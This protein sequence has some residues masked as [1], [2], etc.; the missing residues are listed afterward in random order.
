MY[1]FAISR[2]ELTYSISPRLPSLYISHKRWGRTSM[3]IEM[4]KVV[5]FFL[6]KILAPNRSISKKNKTGNNIIA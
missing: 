1:L 5:I 2:S 4:E 6:L 3:N